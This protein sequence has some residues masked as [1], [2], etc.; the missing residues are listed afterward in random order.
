MVIVYIVSYKRIKYLLRQKKLCYVELRTFH[1]TFFFS[2][3]GKGRSV[4][5]GG[6]DLSGGGGRGDLTGGE[7]TEIC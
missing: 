1:L 2:G 7:V 3:G 6:G 5:G 4:G